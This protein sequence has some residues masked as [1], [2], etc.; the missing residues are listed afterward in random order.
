MAPLFGVHVHEGAQAKPKYACG[1]SRHPLS[2]QQQSNK[3]AASSSYHAV[4]HTHLPQQDHSVTS[5][6][7]IAQTQK[8][9]QVFLDGTGSLRTNFS[10]NNRGQMRL[11][12]HLCD[13]IAVG[14]RQTVF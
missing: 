13:W 7:H 14:T 1:R 10:D 9:L 5:Q 2:N 8:G 4:H 12:C 11:D 6:P 3:R